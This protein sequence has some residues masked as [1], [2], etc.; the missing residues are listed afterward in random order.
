MR[1]SSS[2]FRVLCI[3]VKSSELKLQNVFAWHVHVYYSHINI[4]LYFAKD[5]Y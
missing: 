4:K 3:K 1:K 2:F 5:R